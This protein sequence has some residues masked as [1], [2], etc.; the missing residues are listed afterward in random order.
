MFAAGITQPMLDIHLS[1]LLNVGELPSLVE[2][3]QE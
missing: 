1:P 3:Y 2:G